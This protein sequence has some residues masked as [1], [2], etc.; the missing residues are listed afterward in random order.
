MATKRKAYVKL[1]CTV[2]KAFA[3]PA[4]KSKMLKKKEGDQKLEFQRFCKHCKKHTKHKE[5]KR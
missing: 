5:S 2:C 3:Y 4:H 1:Q